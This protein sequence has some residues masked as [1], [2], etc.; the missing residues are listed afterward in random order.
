MREIRDSVH[1][2]KQMEQA[3]LIA[4][5]WQDSAQPATLNDVV[6]AAWGLTSAVFFVGRMLALYR[7]RTLNEDFR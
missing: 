3:N 7:E 6:C 4:Q 2:L 1:A 5:Q